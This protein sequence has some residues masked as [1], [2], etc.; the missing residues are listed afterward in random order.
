MRYSQD[1]L[2]HWVLYQH[3]SYIWISETGM[4]KKYHV[5]RLNMVMNV[6]LQVVCEIY[7]CPSGHHMSL[8]ILCSDYFSLLSHVL[9]YL[10]AEDREPPFQLVL[11]WMGR[12]PSML[13][14]TAQHHDFHIMP[15]LSHMFCCLESVANYETYTNYTVSVADSHHS[16]LGNRTH[17]DWNMNVFYVYWVI[18][19]KVRYGRTCSC[20]GVWSAWH[21]FVC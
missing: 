21:C 14:S 20:E 10:W 7:N 3:Q 8:F 1:R 9:S 13:P 12:T 18:M 19:C 15:V 16:G 6:E 2:F 4:A 5:I 17:W 11:A